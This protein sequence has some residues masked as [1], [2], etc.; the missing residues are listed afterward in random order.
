MDAKSRILPASQWS[1]AASDLRIRIVVPATIVSS[2]DVAFEFACLLLDF[3]APKGTLLDT[4]FNREGSADRILFR[5]Y[6]R[7]GFASAS[8][9]YLK[10]QHQAHRAVRRTLA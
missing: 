7:T 5:R 2:T 6:Y 4:L 9:G 10:H 1:R 8:V 3:G